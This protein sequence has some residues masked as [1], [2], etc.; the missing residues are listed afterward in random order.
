MRVV[1]F[2]SYLFLF[3]ISLYTLR[4]IVISAGIRFIEPEGGLKLAIAEFPEVTVQ[5][6]VYNEKQVVKRL[7]NSVCSLDY[8]HDKLQ[9]QVLDDSTDETTA[10][11]AAS[12]RRWQQSGIDI[13]HL[14]RTTRHRFKAGNLANGL[15]RATGELVAIFDA[16]YL[17]EPAWLR[18]AV[19]H[20]L[21]P[22]TDNLGLVQTRWGQQNSRDSI[23]TYAQTLSVE[24]FAITQAE[25]VR[26]GLWSSFFGSAGLWRRSC[27]DDVGG[28]EA[29]NALSEDID[30]AY[31]AQLAG[32][33]ISYDDALLAFA[34]LPNG[35]LAYKQQ[36]FRW[37]KGNTQVIR[38]LWP[39]ILKSSFSWLQKWDAIFFATWPAMNLLYILFF[40]FKLPQLMWPNPM[41]RIQDVLLAIGI[42]LGLLLSFIDWIGGRGGFPIH[43]FLG[44]GSTFNISVGFVAGFVRGVGAGF[45][46]TPR[47]GLNQAIPKPNKILLWTT[48]GELLLCG[49]ALTS[50]AYAS[51]QKNYLALPML[52]LYLLGYGWVGLQSAR[53]IVQFYFKCQ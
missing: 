10:M 3:G 44:V 32:W 25:R 24:E 33:K 17:V 51:V 49:L 26:L 47:T 19:S 11:I 13:S 48:A 27:I 34:E 50:V 43:T 41:S 53:E 35:M 15:L 20:F 42:T 30:I 45:H 31:R 12:V 21:Q 37:A 8:P 46:R 40:F 5:L 39:R 2:I 16:D 6:P 29:V 28:W 23:L 22:N 52:T 9:I 38:E 7:I 1:I 36:Q 4:N 18:Q 14:R